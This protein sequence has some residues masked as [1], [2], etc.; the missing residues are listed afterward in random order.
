MA[1]AR[2][3]RIR[4]QDQPAWIKRPEPPRS[5]LFVPLHRLLS[6]LLPT[7]LHPTNSAGGPTALVAEADRLVLFARAGLPVPRVLERAENHIILSDCGQHFGLFLFGL[8][9]EPDRIRHIGLAL[10]V[11]MQIHAA[12]L[13]HGRPHLKDFAFAPGSGIS[14][15]DLEEDPIKTMSLAEAQAR[16]FWLFLGSACEFF[17][18]PQAEM[19]SLH[20]IYCARASLETVQALA[21]LGAALRPYRRLIAGLRAQKWGHD[22]MGTYWATKAIER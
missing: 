22:I 15:L 12:G 10:E 11:L 7:A 6:L 8:T 1:L 18:D 20:A 21:K 5:S 2:T 9:S 16:D 4:F 3:E 13:S 17:S 14:I 19:A